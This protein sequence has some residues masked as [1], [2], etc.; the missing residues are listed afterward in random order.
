[1]SCHCAIMLISKSIRYK[2]LILLYYKEVHFMKKLVKSLTVLALTFVVGYI[3]PVTSYAYFTTPDNTYRG[4]YNNLTNGYSFIKVNPEDVS[5]IVV[6]SPEKNQY[7]SATNG[8]GKMKNGSFEAT[9]S[10]YNITDK[11]GN[12]IRTFNRSLD[13]DGTYTRTSSYIDITVGYIIYEKSL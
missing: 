8:I 2:S 13:L 1:M 10:A 4:T 12:I 9:F 6:Y 7:C 5:A 3:Y 11:S